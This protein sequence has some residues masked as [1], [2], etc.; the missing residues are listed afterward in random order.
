VGLQDAE[1][2]LSPYVQKL[3]CS[4]KD[5]LKSTLT[6]TRLAAQAEL[7]WRQIQVQNMLETDSRPPVISPTAAVSAK[8]PGLFSVLLV[9][10]APT[11]AALPSGWSDMTSDPGP[12]GVGRVDNGNWTVS[13]GGSDIWNAADQFNLASTTFD[14]DGTITTNL[15]S[16][17]N[18]DPWA[19]AGVMFGTPQLVQ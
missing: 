16:L 19:K 1:Q 18:T 6:K 10:T 7:L 2:A 11:W 3:R 14:G 15:A 9:M 13:G 5:C 8:L 12:G 17:Q 4:R